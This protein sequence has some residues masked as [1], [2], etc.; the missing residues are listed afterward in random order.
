LEW[1]INIEQEEEKLRVIAYKF[2]AEQHEKLFKKI[3][4]GYEGWDDIKNKEM[5][6]SGLINNLKKGLTGDNLV[7]IA[8]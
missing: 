3:E 8:N 6:K 4:E 5:I 1:E 7:D 2:T